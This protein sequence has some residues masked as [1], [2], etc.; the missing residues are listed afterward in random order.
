[1]SG[2]SGS[3]W[4]ATAET[5]PCVSV[6]R[7]PP[8]LP[9]AKTVSPWRSVA[10]GR[11]RQRRRLQPVD[12]QEREV[13]LAADADDAR[14]QDRH[15][16][17]QRRHQRAVRVGRRHHD[18][19]ALRAADHVGVG[20]D[21]AF[22]IDDEARAHRSL[23]RHDRGVDRAAAILVACPV[24]GHHDLDDARPHLPRQRVDR[25]VHAIEAVG[26]RRRAARGLLREQRMAAGARGKSGQAR[27]GGARERERRVLE[28][29]MT[30]HSWRCLRP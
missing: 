7:S 17:R 11:Q 26:H 18:L 1:M 22:G 19:D 3:V 20:H 10:V 30:L 8:G 2:E 28:T 15:L 5:R 16:G 29:I 6:L 23:A 27:P 25:L 12:F 4:R 24:A 14:R 13:D 21:V 9:N